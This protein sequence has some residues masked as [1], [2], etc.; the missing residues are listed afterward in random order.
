[1]SRVDT[2]NVEF[3]RRLHSVAMKSTVDAREA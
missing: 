1:M 2:L 3:G